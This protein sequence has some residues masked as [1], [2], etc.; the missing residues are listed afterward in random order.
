MSIL[1][2]IFTKDKKNITTYFLKVIKDHNL[3]VPIISVLSIGLI[4]SF[5]FSQKLGVFTY[6]NI[7]TSNLGDDYSFLFANLLP[8]GVFIIFTCFTIYCFFKLS[9]YHRLIMCNNII[10]SIVLVVMATV[11]F[12]Y[13]YTFFDFLFIFMLSYLILTFIILGLLTFIYRNEKIIFNKKFSDLLKKINTKT[14]KKITSDLFATFIIFTIIP[15][16]LL[17]ISFITFQS[18]YSE[19]EDNRSFKII[20]N[21]YVVLYETNDAYLCSTFE[22]DD[23]NISVQ[24]KEQIYLDKNNLLTKEKTFD[25]VTIIYD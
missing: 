18:S 25:N 24:T 16:V 14:I 20:E 6:Y 7:D 22:I 21:K 19:V 9:N 12:F 8:L 3:L 15:F 2:E 17:M 10:L 13:L 4:N 1:K 23:D 5:I 11:N